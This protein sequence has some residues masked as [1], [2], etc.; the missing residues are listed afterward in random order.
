M[1]PVEV[2]N[3]LGVK[4]EQTLGLL[5]VSSA[6][7]S[8]NVTVVRNALAQ[9]ILILWKITIPNQYGKMG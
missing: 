4:T 2:D 7:C 9:I 8:F 3:V 6:S 5:L 1:A